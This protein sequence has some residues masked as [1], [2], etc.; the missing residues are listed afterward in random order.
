MTYDD[1]SWR[2]LVEHYGSPTE[3]RRAALREANRL[4][5]SA[6]R[7]RRDAK[8]NG[9]GSA[10]YYRSLDRCDQLEDEAQRIRASLPRPVNPCPICD[11]PMD[12][13]D[14]YSTSHR[15]SYEAVPSPPRAFIG[16]I[17]GK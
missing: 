7:K 5:A 14:S 3:A 12:G 11:E 9:V 8:H 6:E 13:G 4:E 10:R 15:C 17:H 2:K 1:D 16:S